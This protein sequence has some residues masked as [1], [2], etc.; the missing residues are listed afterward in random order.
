[1]KDTPYVRFKKLWQDY[2]PQRPTPRRADMA[3]AMKN[4]KNHKI[5]DSTGAK[6]VLL[7]P[8]KFQEK[9]VKLNKQCR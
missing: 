6:C 3:S 8:W 5:G 2:P 1:M 4:D 9:N 7:I